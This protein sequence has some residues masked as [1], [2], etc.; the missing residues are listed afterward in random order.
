MFSV[1]R[2]SASYGKCAAAAIRVEQRRS[3]EATVSCNTMLETNRSQDEWMRT[4]LHLQT[5]ASAMLYF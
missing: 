1:V 4:K 3:K 2:C 5:F